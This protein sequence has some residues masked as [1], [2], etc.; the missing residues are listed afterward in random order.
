MNAFYIERNTYQE[1]RII[2]IDTIV[3]QEQCRLREILS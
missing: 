3:N 1:M 2:L